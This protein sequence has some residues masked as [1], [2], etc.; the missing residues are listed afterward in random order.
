VVSAVRAAL[1]ARAA[2]TPE[3]IASLPLAIPG[4]SEDAGAVPRVADVGSVRLTDDV[5][6]GMADF[7]GIQPAL[8]GIVIARRD[9][10]IPAVVEAVRRTLETHRRALPPG[11]E[12]VTAYD[13]ADLVTRARRT[14]LAALGE[15]VG[16]V[17]VVTLV[18]LLHWRS[19]LLPLLTLPVVLLDTLGA[20]WIL[21][22]PGTIMSLSGVGI[23]LGMAVDADVVALEACHRRLEAL[24]QDSSPACRRAH[25]IAAAGSFAP[26]I[27]TSLLIAGIAFLPVFAFT[28][29]SGRLLRPLALTKTL[30]IAAAA[31]VSVT[32]APALRER[33]LAGRV[34]P[35][36]ENPITRTLVRIYRPFVHFA[37]TRPFLT[38][39]TAGLAALSCIPVASRLG[40]E[41]LPRID[42]GDLLFMPT[43]LPGVPPEQAA[44]ELFRQDRALREF[45]EVSGIFGKVGRADTA[46]DPAPY[47]M[48]ET[49]IRLRPR[50]AW[51]LLPRTRWYSNWAPPALARVLGLAWP[52]ATEETPSE[53]VNRLDRATRL[54]GW[55][56]GWTAPARARMDM[57]ATGVRTPVGVRIVAADPARL[58]A[59]GTAVRAVLSRMPQT[60]G[61]VFESLGG[62]PWLDFEPD[63]GALARFHVDPEIARSM[64]NLLVTGGQVGEV[65]EGG[66]PLRV[67]VAPDANMHAMGMGPSAEPLRGPPDQLREAT[68]RAD[69]AGP[70]V[71]LGLLGRT[72]YVI[73]P[74]QIRTERGEMVGYVHVDLMEGLDVT[75]Y[76]RLA[77]EAVDH[78]LKTGE[79]SLD[80]RERIEWT[81]QYEL[82]RAGE[83]RLKWIAPLAVV[84]MLALLWLQFRNLTESLIV[85]VSIP[86]AL[87]GS[88]W[89]LY[90]LSYPLSAPVWVGLLSTIGLAMQTGVVMVVYIDEAFYRR[91]SEGRLLTRDDIVL[92]HAEGTIRRLRPK[93]MTVTTMA[94]SLLPLLW[95]QGAGAE[96]MKRVAAPM[97]GGLLTSALLTLEVLPVIYT[98]WRSSQLRRAR[99]LGVPLATIVGTVPAWVHRAAAGSPEIT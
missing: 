87:V 74:A 36:F 60:R 8:G 40:R 5:P 11:V 10:D 99:R 3:Q 53:L 55:T 85:L 93:I 73:E 49:T 1:A 83:R 26:A 76:V 51:P 50:S 46:T 66:R 90:G 27:L 15:E 94:A 59:L 52:E 48:A 34:P 29:E 35:E 62:E 9:A 57:M 95:A 31:L 14:L 61:A 33:L 22:I 17:V 82:M 37:L 47:S 69:G 65:K 16:M 32:L 75:S 67:R 25:L 80:P 38:L 78:S 96:I 54:P 97:L 77:R 64:A 24:G 23:A 30:V 70:P 72:R 98:I 56:S 18:F 92:A 86:F 21:R 2:A 7:R 42:E 41:F 63:P 12:L 79:I 88:C 71:P 43:T 39:A 28:G 6:T 91:V 84:S 68:V 19:S 89:T 4:A 13:R 20:M 58:D 81:G 45:P 44:T